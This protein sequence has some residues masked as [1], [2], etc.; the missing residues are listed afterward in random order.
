L[1][2]F[3][4]TIDST[5]EQLFVVS[6]LVRGVCEHLETDEFQAYSVEL[7]AVEAVTNAIK[8]AYLGAPGHEVTLQVSFTRERLELDVADQG[9][10]MPQ[11]QIVRLASGSPVCDFDPDCI[12][13]L[14]EGGM[15]L[16]I[17]RHEMDETCYSTAGG[18]NSFRMTKFLSPVRGESA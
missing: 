7:C 18:S 15:G 9:L 16:E 1:G 12:E 4:L 11:E 3:R 14:P 2:R 5:L 8:H 10:R 17:I 6:S 13:D